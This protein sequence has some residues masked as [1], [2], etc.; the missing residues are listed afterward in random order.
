MLWGDLSDYP[1]RLTH[2]H[3]PPPGRP[4]HQMGGVGAYKLGTVLDSK[5]SWAQPVS[6]DSDRTSSSDEA[7]EKVVKTMAKKGRERGEEE[8]EEVVE[9]LASDAST[10]SDSAAATELDDVTDVDD[11]FDEVPYTPRLI[12]FRLTLPAL[13]PPRTFTSMR[14][15]SHPR[16]AFFF[17]PRS[18]LS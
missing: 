6:L 1:V 17:P 10:A 11:P 13:A 16:R 3:L 12:H 4:R 8:E 7:E 14:F 18:P 9:E 5:P 2:C 15:L